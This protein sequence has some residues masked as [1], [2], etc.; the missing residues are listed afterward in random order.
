M[1][2]LLF[3]YDV[4][5]STDVESK[6]LDISK[7]DVER[8]KEKSYGSRNAQKIKKAINDFYGL[9]DK[10]FEKEEIDKIYQDGGAIDWD[11]VAKTKPQI[12]GQYLKDLEEKVEK[13]SRSF[14]LVLDLVKKGAKIKQTEDPKMLLAEATFIQNYIKI[15]KIKEE[16][17][18]GKHYSLKEEQ[19]IRELADLVAKQQSEQNERG[20]KRDKA[21]ADNINNSLK[22][23]EVGLFIIGAMHNVKQY[24]AKDIIIEELKPKGLKEILPADS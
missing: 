15:S 13:G 21:I 4:H 1:K 22:E 3:I 11:T 12:Y 2:K 16:L 10:R 19:E 18:R 23:G 8:I 5:L 17:N 9:L 7:S 14:K 20:E 24:L 6:I